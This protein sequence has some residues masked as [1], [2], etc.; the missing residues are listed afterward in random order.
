M[1]YDF[2]FMANHLANHWLKPMTKK[3]IWLKPKSKP[4]LLALAKINQIA[5]GFSQ[6][7]KMD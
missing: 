6:W 3:C 7:T 5:I 2:R 4:K 1:S